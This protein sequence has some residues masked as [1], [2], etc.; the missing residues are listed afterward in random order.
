MDETSLLVLGLGNPG[1]AYRATRHNVGHWVV[2]LLVRRAGAALRAAPREDPPAVFA[3]ASIGG[4]ELL[5]ANTL[6][7]M[8]DAGRAA[9]ALCRRHGIPPH[10][11]VVV[12][13]DADI[14]L[15]TLRLR[16]GG[17]AGGHNG[18]RS[19]VDH[20]G[21]ADFVRVRLGVRGPGR[22]AADLADYVLSGFADAELPVAERLTEAAADAIETLAREGLAPAMN[23]HN[24]PAADPAGS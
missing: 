14:A 2:E 24:G 1:P 19:L 13:D 22:E 9:A 18:L 21:S 17:G 8:N 6:T 12:H 5:L 23:R 11:L 16:R 3:R 4:R 7:F 15:G 20:L 10:D